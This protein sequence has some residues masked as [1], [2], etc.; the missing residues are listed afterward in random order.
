MLCDPPALEGSPIHLW[1]TNNF[2]ERWQIHH[3][4]VWC[5]FSVC[6][7]AERYEWENRKCWKKSVA[8]STPGWL[9]PDQAHSQWMEI[10]T[11]PVTVASRGLAAACFCSLSDCHSGAI[12]CWSGHLVLN[13]SPGLHSHC[14]HHH[15]GWSTPTGHVSKQ[16]IPVSRE[17]VVRAHPIPGPDRFIPLGQLFTCPC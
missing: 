12:T 15:S 16:N 5:V 13:Y 4:D 6:L 17:A 11:G 8:H 7:I 10:C 3:P 2:S 14:I 9:S 1:K